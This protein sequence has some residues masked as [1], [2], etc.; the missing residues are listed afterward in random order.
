M[1]RADATAH[2]RHIAPNRRERKASLFAQQLY[3]SRLQAGMAN[4]RS[5]RRAKLTTDQ[6]RWFETAVI[7]ELYVSEIRTAAR[8]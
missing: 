6:T 4:I 5:R 3:L 2:R 8:V 7:Q 1:H